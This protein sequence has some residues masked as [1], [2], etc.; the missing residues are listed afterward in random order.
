M[1]GDAFGKARALT[2]LGAVFAEQDQ[3]EALRIWEEALSLQERLKDR[4]G[5]A[6]TLYNMADLHFQLANAEAGQ[7]YL[8]RALEL[9]ERLNLHNVLSKIRDDSLLPEIKPPSL[10]DESDKD[11]GE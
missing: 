6:T 10:P 9:A 2:S 3:Q 11:E 4:A 7:R 8:D 5:M 1:M